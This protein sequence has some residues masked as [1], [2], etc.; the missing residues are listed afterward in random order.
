MLLGIGGIH[1]AGDVEVEVV[2]LNLG[3]IDN[4]AEPGL[5]LLSD[6]NDWSP[7]Y[8]KSFA[9]RGW[10]GPILKSMDY[11]NPSA[12]GMPSQTIGAVGGNVGLV[13]GSASWKAIT[14]M[15]TYRGSQMWEDQGCCA[16][17]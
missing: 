2:L 10:A 12:N 1:V 3:Q 13:D 11:G 6:L 9:P 14:K 7:G 17:W 4:T 16:A 5:V 15:K 8:Q